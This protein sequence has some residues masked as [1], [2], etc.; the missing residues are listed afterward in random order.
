MALQRVDNVYDMEWAPGVKYG[1]V[2]LREEVEQSKYAFGQVDM[3]REAFA[4]H[5]RDL[6]ERHYAFC[7]VLL[8]S[9][10]VLP[11]LE[12]CLKCSHLF[13]IL[14][15]S[16]SVGVTGADR[17]HPAGAAAG[18]RDCEGVCGGTGDGRDETEAPGPRLPGSRLQARC[19]P[20]PGPRAAARSLEPTSSICNESRTPDRTRRRR[21]A[22][23]LVAAAHAAAGGGHRA[24]ARRS[25]AGHGR[26]ARGV[27]HAAASRGPRGGH[28]R[29]AARFSKSSSPA[30]RC[31][32]RRGRTGGRR[33]PRPALRRRTAWRS[34]ISSACRRQ[35]ASYLAFRNRQRG[36]SAVDALPDVLTGMLRGLSFPKQMH[37]DAL[38]DDGK[39]ELTFGRPIRWLLFLYGGRVVPYVI[40]RSAAAQSPLVQEIRSGACHPRT[41][42]PDDQRPRRARDQG[43]DVRRVPRPAGRALRRARSRGAPRADRPRPRNPGRTPRRARASRV[44]RG[45]RPARRGA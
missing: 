42:V 5:H 17:L 23:E 19:R 15:A 38:L 11:A 7:G 30:R 34:A 18:S 41:P 1:A 32:R 43:E 22:R 24:A 39:G 9:G 33:R 13:N 8:R 21:A 31:R 10:L 3:P 6:F 26:A 25:A 14:D 36:K 37:W 20:E 28:R 27:Q 40:R 12:E 45:V 44:G 29:A 35:R 2:R 4:A 16:G